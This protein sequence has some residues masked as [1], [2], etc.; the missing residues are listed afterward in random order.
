MENQK[1]VNLLNDI[2]DENSKFATKKWY[3]INDGSEGNYSPDNEMRFLTSSLKS[4]LCDYSD[5]YTL[6]REILFLEVMI[7]KLDLKIVHHL[8]NPEQK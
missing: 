8:K 1:I 6:S 7:Q 2:D 3:V 5:T 4:S